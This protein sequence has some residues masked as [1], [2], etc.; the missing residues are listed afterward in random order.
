[1]SRPR[2]AAFFDF[3]NTLLAEDGARIGIKYLWQRKEISFFFILRVL[4]ANRYFKR[5]KISAEQMA[6]IV[7]SFYKGKELA[8]FQA[9][10]RDYYAD[11]LKPHLSPYLIDELE[12]HRRRGHVLVL[13]SGSVRYM[14]EPVVEDLGFDHLLCTDLE[15]G[16]D[17]RL[18]GRASGPV[19]VGE[20]KATLA[21]ALAE[22][23][24]IDLPA[25]YAYADHISDVPIME[26]V[27]NPVAV[28]PSLSLEAHAKSRGWPIVGHHH[29]DAGDTPETEL[30]EA[31]PRDVP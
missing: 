10:A 31:A 5:D 26:L 30:V 19:C 20:T 16:G 7:L 6:A 2:V 3:D 4:Y 8:R 27:G 11:K 1:M 14:L 23:Q 15:V 22:T 17:G 25:S 13:L 12:D 9:E 18:T 28:E 29:P 21:K 24:N